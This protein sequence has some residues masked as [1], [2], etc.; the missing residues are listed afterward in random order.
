MEYRR[1]YYCE[2]CMSSRCGA[3][4][5]DSSD[6]ECES[7]DDEVLSCLE[8]DRETAVGKLGADGCELSVVPSR[9]CYR[10]VS[11]SHVVILVC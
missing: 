11:L 6:G 8:F 3:V 7:D 10:N 5:S 4:D 2:A 1:S 9:V